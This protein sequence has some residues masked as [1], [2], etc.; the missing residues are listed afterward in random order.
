MTLPAILRELAA[1]ADLIAREAELCERLGQSIKG[2]YN[3]EQQK[4]V[5]CT[6]A[7]GIA[8]ILHCQRALLGEV[9][10]VEM[11]AARSAVGMRATSNNLTT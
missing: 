3:N 1:T 9:L 5:A 8:Q 7:S 6:Y 10:D 11:A 2:A 4:L